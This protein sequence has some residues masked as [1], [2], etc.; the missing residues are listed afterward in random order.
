MPKI[1]DFTGQVI[2]IWTV[3]EKT[4]KRAEKGGEVVYKCKCSLDNKI[5]YKDTTYLRQFARRH[6]KNVIGGRPRLP[7][8]TE[9]Q[10]KHPLSTIKKFI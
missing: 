6:S 10:R 2:S 9:Y 4:N 3:L 7:Y 1:L 8:I 5:Y